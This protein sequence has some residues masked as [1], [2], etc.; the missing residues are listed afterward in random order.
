MKAFTHWLKQILPPLTLLLFLSKNG[1]SLTF[2]SGVSLI[3]LLISIIS[4][5]IKLFNFSKHKKHLLRPALT[6]IIAIGINLHS[7]HSYNIAKDEFYLIARKI[8]SYCDN[9]TR[10]P[11]KMQ[12]WEK[13]K[14]GMQ[15]KK[16]IGGSITYPV[17][18]TPHDKTFELYMKRFTDLGLIYIGS[19]NRDHLRK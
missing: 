16:L 3:F 12:G 1:I 19:Q 17:I 14:K 10:C 8:E 7:Q 6:S 5:S 11:D 4:I 15:Y 9:N 18:Y 2:L 13:L